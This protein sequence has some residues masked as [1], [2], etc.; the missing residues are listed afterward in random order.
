MIIMYAHICAAFCLPYH[1]GPQLDLATIGPAATMYVDRNSKVYIDSYFLP[2]GC[3]QGQASASWGSIR[4]VQK[5]FDGT[6]YCVY[7]VTRPVV[8]YTFHDVSRPLLNQR[9]KPRH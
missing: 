4:H 2:V 8:I 7:K 6:L 9:P 3:R 5:A 1:I